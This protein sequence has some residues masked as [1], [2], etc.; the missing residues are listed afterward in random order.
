MCS[1]D[2]DAKA[3]GS[4]SDAFALE[5]FK[6]EPL[7]AI[8]HDGDLSGINTNVRLNSLVSHETM[9]VNEKFKSLYSSKYHAMLW[10]GTNKPVKITDSKSGI[11]RR[12]KDRQP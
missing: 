12:C 10:I 7:I 1:S 8:Q 5:P 4:N 11:I 3:L 2:L 6:T 9:M